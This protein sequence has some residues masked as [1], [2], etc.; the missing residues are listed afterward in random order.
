MRGSFAL[1]G[2]Y[3]NQN[4]TSLVSACSIQ[5]PETISSFSL[6][7]LG[8]LFGCQQYENDEYIEYCDC[9]GRVYGDSIK[10]HPD[11]SRF[12]SAVETFDRQETRIE[13]FTND[14]ETVM[15][16]S[17]ANYLAKKT[18]DG[19][20]PFMEGGACSDR[21]K[22]TEAELNNHF[23]IPQDIQGLTTI[24]NRTKDENFLS[25]EGIDD[26]SIESVL[27]NFYAVSQTTGEYPSAF[28]NHLDSSNKLLSLLGESVESIHGPG[29]A[30]M[31]S[32]NQQASGLSNGSSIGVS[33][34]VALRGV[35]ESLAKRFEG[36]RSTQ[37]SHPAPE[38]E[39]IDVGGYISTKY[40]NPTDMAAFRGLKGRFQGQNIQEADGQDLFF[41]QLMCSQLDRDS[42]GDIEGTEDPAIKALDNS[43]LSQRIKNNNS[44]IRVTIRE[45]E[46][47]SEELDAAEEFKARQLEQVNGTLAELGIS[48]SIF[49]ELYDSVE[50]DNDVL[51]IVDEMLGGESRD[52]EA[53]LRLLEEVTR[54]RIAEKHH[55]ELHTAFTDQMGVIAQAQISNDEVFRELASRVGGVLSAH[56]F[57][58]EE[59]LASDS[60]N[61][62]ARY[63]F[64]EDLIG[65]VMPDELRYQ[66]DGPGSVAEILERES[67]DRVNAETAVAAMIESSD[68]SEGEK[69]ALEQSVQTTLNRV[70]SG[71]RN[72][73]FVEGRS[74]MRR[75]S[76]VPS[77]LRTKRRTSGPLNA[78]TGA[79]RLPSSNFARV[80]SSTQDRN[81]SSRFDQAVFTPSASNEALAAVAAQATS[82]TTRI[83]P[84]VRLPSSSEE[85]LVEA[86][87]FEV[88]S[89]FSSEASERISALSDRVDREILAAQEQEGEQDPSRVNTLKR[90]ES[91][92]ADLKQRNEALKAELSGDSAVSSAAN[93][94]QGRSR[95]RAR[96]VASTP[97]NTDLGQS[98]SQD[99]IAPTPSGSGASRQ[100]AASARPSYDSINAEVNS[101]LGL[102]TGSGS[103]SLSSGSLQLNFR[104]VSSISE[105]TQVESINEN[106]LLLSDEQKLAYV[107]NFFAERGGSEA[108]IKQEDG[109][110]VFIQLEENSNGQG[111]S[112]AS[113]PETSSLSE[114]SSRVV[115]RVHQLTNLFSIHFEE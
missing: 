99:I 98:T 109:T 39:F 14:A 103:S 50:N 45:Y 16:A 38:G 61:Y 92:L 100:R 19:S 53:G 56:E 37:N 35:C 51:R 96:S 23:E 65:P 40:L 22:Q 93:P 67:R 6:E 115:T 28:N 46:A 10:N 77:R 64:D 97:S 73:D 52:S 15:L 104:R 1:P 79:S 72:R 32:I 59:N 90:F 68:M 112:I 5:N 88:A 13:K 21:F 24:L 33:A 18:A 66:A 17:L 69:R 34:E 29:S 87:D 70:H 80:E 30:L 8:N 84:S 83:T 7:S 85:P 47:T 58:G 12:K 60:V 20:A 106:F 55:D 82:S 25:S 42:F 9:M 71:R 113:V 41:G 111:R 54:L 57:I 86:S 101:A 48:E 75:V 91:E 63:E 110:V 105:S 44:L 36:A 107:E 102:D 27:R 78:F 49:K 43:E 95:S 31:Q 2:N 89:G 26:S 3:I 81:E 11:Y 62:F 76:G 94:T 114:K 108:Y 4:D 74:S